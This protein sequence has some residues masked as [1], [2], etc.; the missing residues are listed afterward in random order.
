VIQ[1]GVNLTPIILK[2][3]VDLSNLKGR[4]LAV[5]AF[6]VLHQFLALIRT[7]DGTPLMD[8]EGRVTSHLVG[9]AYRTTRLIADYRIKPVFVFDGIPPPIKRAEVERRKASRRKAEEEYKAAIEAADYATA[10]SKAVMTGRLTAELVA[11]SKRLL[12]L[13]GIP[14]I[15]APSEGEAQAAYVARKGDV[16]GVNSRDYDSLLFGA[17]RLVRY[18]TIQ[19]EKYLPSKGRARRLEPE[20]INLED[21]LSHHGITRR[22]LVD[23]AILVGTDFN[24]GIKGIGPKTALKLVKEHCRLEDMPEDVVNKLPS[25]R[26]EIRRLYFEPEVTDEYSLRWGD[27]DE[28]GLH[29]FLCEERSFSKRR[30]EVIVDRMRRFH[31]QKSLSEWIAGAS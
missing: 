30:V 28:D 2:Q 4:S 13:L 9:L 14:W 25:N 6:N 23:L 31:R 7:Q 29:E 24:D 17:P 15:Q 8:E 16:W 26:D 22:Q 5:D 18:V 11:D 1:L 12:D 19:G 21:F 27:L 20:V 10:F 3:V